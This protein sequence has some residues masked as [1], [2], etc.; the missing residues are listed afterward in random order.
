MRKVC[1]RCE[2]PKDPETDFWRCRQTRDGYRPECIACMKSARPKM[3]DEQKLA[4]AGR[5]ATFRRSNPDYN[6]ALHLRKKYNL[7]PDRYWT[8]LKQQGYKCA[9][10]GAAEPG[11]RTKHSNRFSVDHCH[12]TATVR[13]LLCY[14]CNVG[15]GYLQEDPTVVASALRYV[16][17]A[18]EIR[19]SARRRMAPILLAEAT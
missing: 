3:T 19:Q 13:G 6:W 5:S 1:R 8:L 14:K 16:V 10:C 18:E 15:I 12:E 11:G 7:T 17:R 4:H 2:R 9:I